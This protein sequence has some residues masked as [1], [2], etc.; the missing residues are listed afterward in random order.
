MGH[1][2]AGKDAALLE[3]ATLDIVSRKIARGNQP[4]ELTA[5]EFEVLECLMRH[6]GQVVSRDMLAREVW[7]E[8]TW[9]APLHNVIDVHIARLRRKIR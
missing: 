1:R 2:A 5:K 3:R 9:I 6:Q 7:N 8:T 4:I